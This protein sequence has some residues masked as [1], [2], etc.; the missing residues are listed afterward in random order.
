MITSYSK[1]YSRAVGI[2]MADVNPGTYYLMDMEKNQISPRQIL[3]KNLYDSLAE[4][5]VIN[6][7]NRYGDEIQSYF[8]EAVGKKNAPTIVMPHGGPWARDYG[9]SILKFNF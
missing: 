4:M 6:F 9:D 5:K 7:K 3:V 1:D 2:V 8:T